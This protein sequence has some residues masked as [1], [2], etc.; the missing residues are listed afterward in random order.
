[1]NTPPVVLTIAGFDPSSGAGVTAD[2]KTIAAHQCYGIS[3][4]TALTVQSTT[5]VRRIQ[6]VD[7]EII[8]ESLEMLLEDVEIAAVHIGMLGNEAV[9]HTVGEI[10]KKRK[11]PNIVIDPI[12]RSSSGTALLNSQ[13]I[14]AL[15]EILFPMATVITPNVDEAVVLTKLPVSNEAE[16][17]LAAVAL[18]ALGAKSVVITGGHLSKATDLLSIQQGTIQQQV[19]DSEKIP[20]NSTHGTGCAF[21][22]S[23]ACNLAL[24][25]DL[26][27]AVRLAKGYVEAAISHAYPLGKGTG[28]LHHLYR[29]EEKR[30]KRKPDQR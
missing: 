9:V 17:K 25:K 10:L 8:R 22:T 19:F 28:P 29:M 13:G 12:V 26:P 21:S 11:L 24:G 1:M 6:P 4:I 5:G 3:C 18:H 23:L 2:I 30:E 27:E 20:S 7:A 15:K 14:N 16:M